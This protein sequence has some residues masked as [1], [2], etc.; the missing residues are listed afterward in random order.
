M[1]TII[2]QEILFCLHSIIETFLL[3][4]KF[5]IA[6]CRQMLVGND[7]FFEPRSEKF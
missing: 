1:Q 5:S 7:L 3:K 2:Q 4:A 6:L